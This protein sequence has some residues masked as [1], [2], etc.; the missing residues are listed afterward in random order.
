MRRYVQLT[1]TPLEGRQ[2]LTPEALAS[3]LV[4]APT[5]RK[6]ET[7]RSVTLTFDLGEGQEAEAVLR[8]AGLGDLTRYARI[9]H[10]R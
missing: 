3:L 8:C 6:L 2:H 5:V 7:D 9:R 4:E 10:R 1:L